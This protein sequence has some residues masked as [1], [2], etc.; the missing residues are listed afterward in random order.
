MPEDKDPAVEAERVRTVGQIISALLVRTT[1]TAGEL[2]ALIR[3]VH[4]ALGNGDASAAA[5]S[6]TT[7]APPQEPAVP[8]RRSLRP[9]HIVCLECGAKQKTLKR[10]LDVAH[11]LSVEDY[12]AKWNLPKDY[13][14]V[15]PDYAA[16]RSALAKQLGL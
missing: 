3:S 14:M 13:P 9:D 12:R 6:D 1:V 16:Q 4:E 11:G 7:T 8:V 2:P 10:H 15:A 5:T